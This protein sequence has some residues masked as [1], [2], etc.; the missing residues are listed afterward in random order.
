VTV[1]VASIRGAA[2]GP[3]PTRGS[4]RGGAVLG[5]RAAVQAGSIGLL[6]LAGLARVEAAAAEAGGRPRRAVIF[7]FL[8]GGLAQHESFD[9]KPDGPPDIRGEFRAIA[10]RTPGL[11]VS[12]HLPLLAAR[13]DRWAVCRSLTHRSNEHSAGHHIMLTGRS[14]LPA[15][16]D[17]SRPKR[18]DW[19][20][21]PALVTSLVPAAGPL[22]AA[23]V[24]P[25]RLV[26]R[27]G[28]TIPGQFAGMLGPAAEPWF[29][30]CSPY[31]PASY[32]AY[33]EY[34]FHHAKGAVDGP[35]P[36][37]RPID[38]RIPQSLMNGRLLDRVALRDR[39]DGQ[40]A[41]LE[42]SAEAGSIDRYR[43]MATSLLLNPAV[44]GAFDISR[45]EPALREKYG[46]NSF[47]W[48]LLMAARLVEAGVSLVQVN[49]GN[50]EAWDTHQS[51]WTNLRRFLL[52]P[53]DRAVAA[54]LDDLEARGLLESTLVVMAGEFGRTPKIST[55]PGAAE[56]G[57]DH[58]GRLQSVFFAGG[59]VRGGTV[60]GRSDRFGGEPASDAQRPEDLAAT[61]F[62]ALRLP[63]GATWHDELGRPFPLADG[64][65]IPGLFASG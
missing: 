17:P 10:T 40:R 59:G 48:S 29:V 8:S 26:H 60:I 3:T 53:T 6:S 39:L 38:L 61:I 46:E 45:A 1:G 42:R 11:H 62:H 9:P 64:R 2:G 20:S 31:N 63:P 24:L 19:P 13:S 33:P 56:A 30:E 44:S 58:W 12:E 32:G 35:A 16:F 36:L 57:R 51:A 65:P 47:G 5:R 21:I 25:E 27:E 50:N 43:G 4:D 15:G 49:L 28:R 52:P 41:W 23:L 14:E 54:L 34:L 55:L 18:S 37:F 7:V 22:P